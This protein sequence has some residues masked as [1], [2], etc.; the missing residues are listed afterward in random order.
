[1][2]A[3]GPDSEFARISMIRAIASYVVAFVKR[4]GLTPEQAT[5]LLGI[6]KPQLCEL[7]QLEVSTLSLEQMINV[8]SSIGQHIRVY[9]TP[10]PKRRLKRQQSSVAEK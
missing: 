3:G 8:L 1:M 2:D 10:P 7:V 6:S 9:S 4:E 5:K